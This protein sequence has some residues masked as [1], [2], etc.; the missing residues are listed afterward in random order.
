MKQLKKFP[1]AVAVTTLIVALCIGYSVFLGKVA[2]V[3]VKSG[4]FILDSANVLSDSTEST[5]RSYNSSFDSSY[6]SIIAVATVNSTRGWT[7]ENYAYELAEQWQLTQHDLV[8]LLDIGGQDAYFLEGG[9][10]TSL[11]C[12]GMLDTYASQSFFNGDYDGAVLGLFSAMED[13]YEGNAVTISNH[14]NSNAPGYYESGSAGDSPVIGLLFAAVVIYLVI[15]S[16]ERLRYR[17]WYHS[18]GHMAQPSVLFVPIF[19]WHRP[20]SYWFRRMMRT[21]PRTTFY[22]PPAGFTRPGSGFR[23]TSF[24]G[25]GFGSRGGGFGGGHGGGF[26]SR[27]GG[28]GGGRS[29]GFGGRGGGFG[30]RR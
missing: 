2:A 15:A 21:P 18:Y 3:Q 5:L 22:N 16:A 10:W 12:G 14:V 24:R 9:D 6:G 26:G 20:G 4:D 27:G 17:Q 7:M 8:L 23:S 30:G 29:G 1:V 19:P 11:D 28:F 25:G 13:W